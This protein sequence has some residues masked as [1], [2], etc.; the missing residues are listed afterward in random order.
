MYK[1]SSHGCVDTVQ[2]RLDHLATTTINWGTNIARKQLQ[3]TR[4]KGELGVEGCDGRRRC[5]MEEVPMQAH[6]MID[7]DV[8]GLSSL[9]PYDADAAN[10]CRLRLAFDGCALFCATH[11]LSL[12]LRVRLGVLRWAPPPPVVR[13]LHLMDVPATTSSRVSRSCGCPVVT[14]TFIRCLRPALDGCWVPLCLSFV[15]CVR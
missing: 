10:A 2:L 6:L 5:R 8:G 12:V 3:H 13:I 11:H 15:S 4:G 7:V 14:T 9:F 1:C